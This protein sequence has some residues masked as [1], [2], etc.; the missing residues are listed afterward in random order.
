MLSSKFQSPRIKIEEVCHDGLRGKVFHRAW[1]FGRAKNLPYKCFL[2]L[3]APRGMESEYFRY[4]TRIL[5]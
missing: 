1:P 2:T 5:L 4:I 3:L